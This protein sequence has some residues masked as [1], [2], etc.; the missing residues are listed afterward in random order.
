M[1]ITSGAGT[2][3]ITVSATG[4]PAAGTVS[5]GATDACGTGTARSVTLNINSIQPGVIT[6][7]T[8][9]CGLSTAAYSVASVG[10]GYTY[11]WT[12]SMSG[13]TITSGAGTNSI[14]CAG[15]PTGTSTAGL[16][17]VT[18]TN[19]CG[20][21][22]A[23]RSLANTYCHSAIANNNGTEQSG[24]SFSAL[25]PNPT[26]GEFK[27]DVTTDMDEVMTVQVYDVLGNLIISEKHQVTNGTST[28]TTNLESYKAGIYFV[29]L[30]DSN[31]GNIY[32]QNVIKQ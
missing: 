13:W 28:L 15:S 24:N 25:Y 4:T 9:L 23:V 7:P 6:G 32:S 5:V 8:S 2:N 19:S 26:S 11:N 12:L 29:R 14:T 17:K 10:A 16:V 22:S 27:L 3:S 21:T 30:V 18:S 1:T 20:L 31:A